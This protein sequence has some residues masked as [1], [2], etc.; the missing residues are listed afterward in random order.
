MGGL[1]VAFVAGVPLGSVVGGAFG[2][3]TTFWLS[4]AVCAM[5]IALIAV[6]VPP[7]APVAGPRTQISDRKRGQD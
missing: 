1:T 3:R 4:A 7:I 2:W 5:A 6:T